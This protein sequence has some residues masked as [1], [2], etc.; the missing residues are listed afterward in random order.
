[1]INDQY[2]L[3]CA[4]H[5]NKRKGRIAAYDVQLQK[6]HVQQARCL[7]QVK[8]KSKQWLLIINSLIGKNIPSYK[9]LNY[10]LQ[11]CSLEHLDKLTAHFP[12][13]LSPCHI[14][15]LIP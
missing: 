6:E 9:T 3:L 8:R 5:K 11:L 1:M 10:F 4:E 7:D 14:W 15:C 2:S 13:Q 12:V